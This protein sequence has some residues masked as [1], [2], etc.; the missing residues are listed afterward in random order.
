MLESS[1]L[2]GSSRSVSPSEES[3]GV[4]ITATPRRTLRVLVVDEDGAEAF[5]VALRLDGHDVVV[6]HDG[7][8]AMARCQERPPELVLLDIE[9]SGG[10]DGYEVARRLR[11]HPCVRAACLVAVTGLSRQEDRRRAFEAGFDLYLLKPVD[12]AE[13]RELAQMVCGA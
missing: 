12:P 9:L 6:A 11:Q 1:G 7:E 2:S 13:L 10:L 3:T 8:A 4:L 5:A